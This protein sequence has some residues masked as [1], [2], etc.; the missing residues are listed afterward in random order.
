MET[1]YFGRE[2][3]ELRGKMSEISRH[4]IDKGLIELLKEKQKKLTLAK[5]IGFD[6]KKL[7]L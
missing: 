4:V 7:G 1:K 3:A 6:I 2:E 5:D